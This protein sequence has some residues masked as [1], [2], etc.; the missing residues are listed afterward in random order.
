MHP[1]H[2]ST[3]GVSL[4]YIGYGVP[5]T[6]IVLTEFVR[7]KLSDNQMSDLKLFNREI[8]FWAV[9]AYK[10]IGVFLFGA[11]VTVLTTDIAKNVIGRLRPHFFEVCQPI[12]P[13]GTNCSNPINFNRYIEKFTC[14][15]SETSDGVLKDLRLSFPS[16]HSSF[17]IYTMLFT[18]IYLH[19]RFNWS[20]S[21]LFKP[22]VQF[23]VVML[24]WITALSRISDY[25]HHC[26]Y[27]V[28]VH[29]LPF[30]RNSNFV[31]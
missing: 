23:F 5:I 1:Y 14:S 21:K 19:K 12:L 27:Q 20:K 4:D 9:N 3:V 6:L 25:K 16:G 15:N 11:P 29:K 7:W 26:E 30:V 2:G 24:A 8:P 10:Y 17:S 18:A 13:D 31:I 28:V 22:F